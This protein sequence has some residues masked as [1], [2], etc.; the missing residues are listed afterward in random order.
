MAAD[1]E[2]AVAVDGMEA[3]D[4][5]MDAI[6]KKKPYD[7]GCIDI[8]MPRVDGLKFVKVV[9]TLEAQHAEADREPLGRREQHAEAGQRR[10]RIIM[11][12]ALADADYVDGAFKLGCDAYASKPVDTER[13]VEVMKNL[14]LLED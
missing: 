4:L 12:T 7:L 8:M 14:G 5:Y 3:L 2:V 1:G 9:R 6:K 13:V 11:M 10:L